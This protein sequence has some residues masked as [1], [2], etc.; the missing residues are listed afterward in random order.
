MSN[1]IEYFLIYNEIML[2]NNFVLVFFALIILLAI[3][4][5]ALSA[6]VNTTYLWILQ[7]AILVITAG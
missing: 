7:H 6:K 1:F 4:L 2:I 5:F 3:R